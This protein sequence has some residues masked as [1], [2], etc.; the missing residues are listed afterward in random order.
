MFWIG[1][2][3]CRSASRKLGQSVARLISHTASALRSSG[4]VK[5]A[6]RAR[7]NPGS[8]APGGKTTLIAEREPDLSKLIAVDVDPNRLARVRENLSRGRLSAEVVQGDSTEPEKW[9]D[10]EAFDPIDGRQLILYERRGD[11]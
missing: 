1:P 6:A 2:T 3:K 5:V 9:W 4:I 7:T 8:A 10:G 11:I